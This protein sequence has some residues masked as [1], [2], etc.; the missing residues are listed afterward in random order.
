MSDNNTKPLIKR[1]K[2]SLIAQIIAIILVVMDEKVVKLPYTE[3]VSLLKD[4]LPDALLCVFAGM[5][6]CD[7]PNPSRQSLW[8]RAVIAFLENFDGDPE[9]V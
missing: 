9:E 2:L 3:K 6:V 5:G 8:K 4:I 7:T 1:V